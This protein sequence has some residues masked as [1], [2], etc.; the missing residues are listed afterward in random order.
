MSIRDGICIMARKMR[1][2]SR[3]YLYECNG[4][5]R[6][7]VSRSPT[8]SKRDTVNRAKLISNLLLHTFYSDVKFLKRDFDRNMA[9]LAKCDTAGF[10]LSLGLEEIV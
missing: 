1:S 4:G 3:L 6:N 5:N 2:G 10:A 9:K 8:F 7:L